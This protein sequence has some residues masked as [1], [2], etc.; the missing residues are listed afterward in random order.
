MFFKGDNLPVE[1]DVKK[2]LALI[3]SDVLLYVDENKSGRISPL[4]HGSLERR[5]YFCVKKSVCA[6]L[7]RQGETGDYRQKAE[8]TARAFIERL[9][10][11]G[12]AIKADAEATVAGDPSAENEEIVIRCFPGFSAI[13]VYRVAHEFYIAGV[14]YFPRI[15]TEYAHSRTGI[16]INAGAKIGKSFFIDHGTGVVIGET[17]E[18]GDNC[19]IYQGV[20]LG[21]LSLKDRCVCSEKRHPTIGNNVIIYANA[22][23]LGGKTVI[24]DGAII[25]GNAF[26]IKSVPSGAKVISEPT[27][28]VYGAEGVN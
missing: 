22:T 25:G 17:A 14:P 19:R 28:T 21:A 27:K 23:V 4:S 3:K 7:K 2:L 18:I 5:I 20:T 9:P 1:A 8:K 26:I 15:L 6:C 13:S 12:K 16:D 24:G 10:Q 11:L